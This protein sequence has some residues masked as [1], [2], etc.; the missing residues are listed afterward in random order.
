MLNL[1]KY[2]FE[3]W[4]ITGTKS[5]IFRYTILTDKMIQYDPF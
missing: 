5:G 1:M 4:S 3:K 2:E